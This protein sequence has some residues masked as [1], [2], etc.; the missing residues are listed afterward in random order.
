MRYDKYV[1]WLSC[2]VGYP[3]FFS[4]IKKLEFSWKIFEKSS[5][6]KFNE[7]PSSGSRVVICGQTDGQTDRQTW[8]S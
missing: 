1:Y 7:N 4:D 3:L 5:N 2:I 8:Q 6:I